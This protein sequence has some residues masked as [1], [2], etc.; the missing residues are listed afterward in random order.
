MDVR[1][2]LTELELK[3]VEQIAGDEVAF[4]ALKKVLLAS[5]YFDGTIQKDVDS[6][7][8]KNFALAIASEPGITAEAAGN[9]LLNALAGVQL[10]EIGF[11]DLKRFA[12]LVIPPKNKKNEAR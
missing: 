9:K 12:V 6:E 8:Q 4:S 5:V 2:L 3:K 11:K 1:K 7:S 10:L